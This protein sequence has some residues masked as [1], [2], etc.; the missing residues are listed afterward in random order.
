MV[1][2]ARRLKA[3][4][5]RV[6]LMV[7]TMML[8]Q[9]GLPALAQSAASFA[10]KPY[11]VSISSVA[12]SKS[13]PEPTRL[14]PATKAAA[15]NQGPL[16]II[17]FKAATPP[18]VKAAQTKPLET[19]PL[20]S[21]S[22]EYKPLEPKPLEPKLLEIKPPAMKPVEHPRA[23]AA[24]VQ[25]LPAL[26]INETIAS[27]TPLAIS[28]PRPD[29]NVA[30]VVRGQV[31]LDVVNAALQRP[32]SRGRHRDSKAV[33]ARDGALSANAG[34]LRRIVRDTRK[35]VIRDLPEALA[36]TLPWVDKE[37]KGEPFDAVLDR[38]ADDLRRANS[39][40]PAWALPAQREIRALSKR[41]ETLSAPPPLGEADSTSPL[42][43]AIS[44]LDERPFRP[45]PIW[46]GASGRPEAQTRPVTLLTISGQQT[47]PRVS[48]IA[49][50]YIPTADDNDGNPPQKTAPPPRRSP[51][52][53]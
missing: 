50:A 15:P 18:P 12:V 17:M 49:S 2:T 42:A 19:K 41:L 51:H 4:L 9:G 29:L 22:L 5:P 27:I 35:S 43:N 13:K 30:E 44:G 24:P 7:V 39:A 25:T 37:R 20:E 33:A 34:P 28:S 32:H 3:T 40:D 53:K 23:E 11:V 45:R 47:G 8:I 38:V 6:T 31:S 36:D 26:S 52:A 48:G 21:K 16:P 1:N 14:P 10:T 46:P